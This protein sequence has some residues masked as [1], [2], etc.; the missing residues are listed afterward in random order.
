MLGVP[1]RVTPE[2]V[3]CVRFEDCPNCGGN[4]LVPVPVT[5]EEVAR[6]ETCPECSGKGHKVRT[7]EV[8][9]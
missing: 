4:G 3:N 5:T 1:R 2:P 8:P 6:Y 7:L 9:K